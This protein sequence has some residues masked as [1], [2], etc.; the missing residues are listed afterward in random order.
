MSHPTSAPAAMPSSASDLWRFLAFMT[1]LV[2][3]VF[4]APTVLASEHPIRVS[5]FVIG[6]IIEVAGFLISARGLWR[7]WRD[8]APTGA[9]MF[10]QLQQL[11]N[12]FRRRKLLAARDTASSSGTAILATGGGYGHTPVDRSAPIEEQ[13]RTLERNIIR[14]LKMSASVE[15]AV[16][17]E[18]R[19]RGRDLAALEER[20]TRADQDN[21]RLFRTLVIDGVPMAVTGLLMAAAGFM[22]QALTQGLP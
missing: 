22:L 18:A 3:G 7:T 8:N 16:Q 15:H 13:I 4:T 9:P 14:A 12:R 19:Q 5:L 20:L 1:A 2:A 17:K 6:C 10:P 21:V 11:L